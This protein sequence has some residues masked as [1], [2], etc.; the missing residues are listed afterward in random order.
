MKRNKK[1][2][3]L[4]VL[5]AV[6]L[7]LLVARSDAQRPRYDDPAKTDKD[8]PFQGEYV[9]TVGNQKHGI[10]VIALGKGEFQ[11]YVFPG[12]LPGDG[13]T[14]EEKIAVQAKGKRDG[15]VVNFTGDE[16][17]NGVIRNG[18]ITVTS[19]SGE[20]IGELKK[21]N[22]KSKTLGQ[23][24]PKNAVVL[25]DGTNVDEW[26]KGR[27]T[28]DGLLMEGTTSKKTFGSHKIHIEFRLPY[29]PEDRG[30][31]R[32]NSGIYV[33]GRYEVQML[34]SFGLEGKMNECGGLYSVAACDL[35]M[36]YPPLSWQTYDIEF[37]SAK[38]EDG[39]LVSN[40][41]ITVY[42]NGVKIHDNVELPGNRNTTAAPL[43][44]GPEKGP[45]FLQNHGCP[46]RY[47]NIWVVETDK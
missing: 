33:Q 24:P 25:F 14:G 30:Q 40:P 4:C 22:R 43:K 38:Y 5:T 35:N 6:A 17:G 10:Q 18:I 11:A 16:H 37:T 15:D 44:A 19:P 28:P 34:D 41:R 27:M 23:K 36:C 12:G 20:K 3:F 8:F 7:M 47:R 31:G 2:C 29:M 26:K 9:G 32:G 21:A 46:V 13:W 42:H 39:K 1:Y 45:I